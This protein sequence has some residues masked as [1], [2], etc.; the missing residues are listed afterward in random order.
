MHCEDCIL[1]GNVQALGDPSETILL[2]SELLV[3]NSSLVCKTQCFTAAQ[4]DGQVMWPQ[5]YP[6]GCASKQSDMAT[7]VVVVHT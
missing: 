4:V 1:T 3:H 5:L 2:V 6:S 7:C